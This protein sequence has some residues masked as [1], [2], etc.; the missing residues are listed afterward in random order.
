MAPRLDQ[1]SRQRR[2]LLALLEQ[3][4]RLV[5]QILAPRQLLK[6]S[7]YELKTRCGKPCCH[8]ATPGGPLHAST[9]LSWSQDGASQL[10]SVPAA[11]RTR[12]QV[13]AQ[14]YRRFRQCRA[15]LVRLHRQVLLAVD[16]LEKALLLPP[17][18]PA[19]SGRRRR[20]S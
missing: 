17:P 8:C 16:R 20:R 6:G 19:S 4:R 13:L 1:A 11:D 18:P 2:V 5:Q 7:I 15:A 12:L 10:R 3:G 14:D 9:V